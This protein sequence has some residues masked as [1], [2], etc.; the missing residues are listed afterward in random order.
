MQRILTSLFTLS[1]LALG[2]A[3][4]APPVDYELTCVPDDVEADVVLLGVLSVTE[5]GVKVAL[6]DGVTCEAPDAIVVSPEGAVTV[7]IDWTGEDGPVVTVSVFDDESGEYVEFVDGVDG[8]QVVDVVPL[9]AVE[10]MQGA[11]RNRAAAM[12][13]REAG[14][15]ERTVGLE[16]ARERAGERAQGRP[17]QD[18]PNG[19]LDEDVDEDLDDEDLDEDLDD[20][21]EGSG[22]AGGPPADVTR[23]RR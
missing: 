22:E 8:E 4:A 7:A 21:L 12:E 3:L 17:F 14:Q 1:L 11:H 9:V 16:R 5:D 2:L 23:G 6:V 10:G 20:E 19:D 13:R 15:E 18:D